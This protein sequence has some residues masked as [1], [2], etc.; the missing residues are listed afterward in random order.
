MSQLPHL[1]VFRSLFCT[2]LLDTPA[3]YAQQTE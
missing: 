2:L 1:L 3:T